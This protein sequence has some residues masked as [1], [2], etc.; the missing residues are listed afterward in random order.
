LV[1]LALAV[2]LVANAAQAGGRLT[3]MAPYC[4]ASSPWHGGYYHV[5]YGV[6]VALVVPPT[7]EFQT[8]WGWGVGNTRVSVN[9]HQFRRNYP[10]PAYYDAGT[11]QPTPYWP[12]DTD[13]FGVY[14]VRGPW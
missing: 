4:A 11:Y 2:L 14:Y 12:S 7:A 6:P 10:G 3:A 5:S 8:H 13:Q 1:I 9:W